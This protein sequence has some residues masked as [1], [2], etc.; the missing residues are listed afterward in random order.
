MRRVNLQLSVDDGH[1]GGMGWPRKDGSCLVV[2][3]RE[4]TTVRSLG[5]SSSSLGPLEDF[6]KKSLKESPLSGSL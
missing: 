6:S 2:G 4:R 1:A 5:G 3:G